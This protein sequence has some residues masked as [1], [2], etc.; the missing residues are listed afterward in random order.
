MSSNLWL[1]DKP[2]SEEKLSKIALRQFTISICRANYGNNNFPYLFNA[3]AMPNALMAYTSDEPT[4]TNAAQQHKT[5]A[6][7]W[8]CSSF[9]LPRL[10]IFA[11]NRPIEIDHVFR[12]RINIAA[13]VKKWP[14]PDHAIFEIEI[15]Q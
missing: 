11:A 13:R 8:G 5:R 10:Q 2:L 15:R 14:K 1:P 3:L 4:C 7:I 12:I 6:L 9:A